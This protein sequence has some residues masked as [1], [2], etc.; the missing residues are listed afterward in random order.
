MS[1]RFFFVHLQ[2]TAGTSLLFRLRR[3]FARAQI[4][5]LE[6]DKG[7]VAAVISVDHLRERFA[8]HR[9]Q[10]RVITGH[11]PLCV[12]ELLDAPFTTLTLLREPVERTLS[13]LRHHREM[14]PGDR[15]R[16]LE[17]IYDD[18]FRFHGLIH[19]HMVKMYS[20]S[21]DEMTDGALTHVDFTAARL[22]RAKDR[23]AAVDHI[24]LQ[25]DFE[26]FCEQLAGRYAWDLGEPT[27]VNRTKPVDVPASF[28]RRIATDNSDDIELYEHGRS[29][30]AERTQGER[31]S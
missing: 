17:A 12:T 20:L 4:Y 25:D 11:F 24:G 2:K 31:C 3:Q 16:P 18:P 30:V 26:G 29:L 23:L 7:N 15:D 27:R 8:E 19:N 13:Y 1:E 22:A 28:R 14:T 5:P 21:R 6:A 10:L 9:D